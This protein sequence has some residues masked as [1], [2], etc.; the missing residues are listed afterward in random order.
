VDDPRPR[1]SI[2]WA[3]SPTW[4][5]GLK[6]P[7]SNIKVLVE[8]V[9]RARA[10]EWKE[11]KGLLPR[12][13]QGAAQGRAENQR[14]CGKHDEP[15]RVAVRAVREALDNL[16]YDA[17]IAAVRVDD[18]RAK[19]ADTIAAPCSSASTEKPEPA[20]NHL[21]ARTGL[22]ASPS[23]LEI[24]VDKLQSNRR[25]QSRLKKQMEKAQKEYYSTRR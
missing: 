10:V 13:R 23:I 11:D 2:R 3:A 1:T 5:R 22:T 19:L 12:R 15:R 16:H 25:I 21:A 20:R 7:D 6:L 18:F 24:E 14:R 4:S 17:M 9:D 8:G